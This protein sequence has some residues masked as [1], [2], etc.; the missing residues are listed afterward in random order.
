MGKYNPI[1]KINLIKVFNH[2]YGSVDPKL[3]NSLRGVLKSAAF[4]DMFGKQVIDEIIKRTESGV[5]R[6]G[7]PFPAYSDAYK[8]SDVF[9]IYHKTSHVNLE[10]TGEMMSSLKPVNLSDALSIEV[11]G[12]NNQ[13][14]ADGHINGLGPKKV[15]RDFLGLPDEEINKIMKNTVEKFKNEEFAVLSGAFHNQNITDAFG[16]V[17]NQPEFNIGVKITDV[18]FGI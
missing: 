7:V 6:Y 8:N 1:F 10:L 14:K 13:A 18:L 15:K 9:K 11:I 4:R 2:T 17:G 16:Q 5:D 3:A 12:E